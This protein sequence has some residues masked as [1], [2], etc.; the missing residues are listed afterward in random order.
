M[1]TLVLIIGIVIA[2]QAVQSASI[3]GCP[4][5]PANNIWNSP[6]DTLPVHPQSDAF[7]NTIGPTRPLHADFGAGL[8]EGHPMGIPYVVVTGAQK[9]K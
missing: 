9:K 5:F 1:H 3:G 7:I 8:Y 4:V 2:L 6:I